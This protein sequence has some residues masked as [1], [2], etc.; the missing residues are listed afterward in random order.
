MNVDGN[1][2]LYLIIM[3]SICLFSS[4]LTKLESSLSL[5]IRAQSL[6]L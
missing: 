1:M 6:N 3:E 2:S 5:I 4:K